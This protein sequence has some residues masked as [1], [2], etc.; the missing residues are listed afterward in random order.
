ML[1]S[2]FVFP[3]LL[4]TLSM[5]CGLLVVHLTG[6]EVPAPLIAPVGFTVVLLLGELASIDSATASLAPPLAV[7]AAVAGFVLDRSSRRARFD[8]F[9][10]L[11]GLGVFLV[12]AAPV[13]ASGEPTFTG[14]IKLDDTATWLALTDRIA[15]HG[16]DLSGLGPSTYEAT[17]ALN[18]GSGYPIG[19]FTPLAICSSIVGQDPAWTFQPYLATMATLLAFCL[20]ELGS[21]LID[22][23]R[24]R[25]TVAFLA[26]QPA[27]LFGYYLWGGIKEIAAA[28]L[29]ALLAALLPALLA[30]GS[31][32]ARSALPAALAAASILAVLTA[33]GAA[34][35]LLP[36][37]VVAGAVS[38]RSDGARVTGRRL[39]IL[40]GL[41]LLASLPWLLD[42]G[43]LPRDSGALTSPQELGNLIG[44]LSSWQLVG[45]WP[46]GDFRLDPSDTVAT[47]ALIAIALL[48]A[49]IGL[50]RLWTRRALGPASFVAG[51][52]LGAAALALIG[53]PWVGGKA[54]ATGSAAVLFLACVGAA[55]LWERGRR[56]E[57]GI[58]LGLIALGVLWSN[59]LAYRDAFVAPHASLAELETIG[60]QIA[61]EGPTLMTEYEPYGARHFLR[62]AEPEGA[63]ELRRRQV[64]LRSGRT[65]ETGATADIDEF[66]L[67]A[68]MPYRTLV[69][70][71]SPLASRPPLPFQLTD[72]GNAYEVWQLD[73]RPAPLA[74]VSLQGPAE[75]PVA[76]A[77]CDAI[78]QLAERPGV[79]HLAA[80][81]RAAPIVV[82]FSGPTLASGGGA[83]QERSYTIL[84]EP[85]A[86]AGFAAVPRRGKYGIWLGGSSRGTVDIA[87]DGEV[88]AVS[89]PE[90]E[91]G[92]GYRR[93]GTV[94]LDPGRHRLDL[95]YEEQ[96]PL[97]P[98]RGGEFF[99]LGPLVLSTA[100]AADARLETVPADEADRLCGRQL[101]WV[102]AL[103]Y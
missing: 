6:R 99:A 100:T 76:A 43:L 54:L 19:A 1:A 36:M 13:L 22:D 38:L 5:G 56:V 102:E 49:A 86:A 57:G 16:R 67:A 24:L 90:L 62:D 70:R 94:A 69:L 72:Q 74:H 30:T 52:V 17:L 50:S 34:L 73:G 41:T 11:A 23:R 58:V 103:P 28:M 96:G 71:R 4:L 25:A 66:A 26:A 78:R 46:V 27:L 63:S 18:L 85:T 89:G 37:L 61:G 21:N 95:H 48:A 88:V 92:G 10:L 80:S 39:A 84:T 9:A 97:V 12:Y 33:P 79:A 2:W 31:R 7:A 75:F 83:G 42:A 65:L 59:A 60:H 68:L 15:E 14:Y 101:D 8:P 98:G 87:I 44:P 55:A 40:A 29:L 64:A 47:V 53:S 91:H 45:I 20:Y 32:N 3:L 77:S 82:P 81:V 35:W 51:L 93:L